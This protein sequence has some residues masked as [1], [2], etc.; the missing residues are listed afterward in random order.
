V[1]TLSHAA[2]RRS[3]EGEN[4]APRSGY[5]RTRSAARST[6]LNPANVPLCI[7]QDAGSHLIRLN[8]AGFRFQF[9]SAAIAP[10]GSGN[11]RASSAS[12]PLRAFYSVWPL[13]A[14]RRLFHSLT[15]SIP[16]QAGKQSTGRCSKALHFK[17]FRRLAG[18]V[19][20]CDGHTVVRKERACP[21]RDGSNMTRNR[22]NP[23]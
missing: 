2:D 10:P 14:A 11:S 8:S 15:S 22:A 18:L 7:R 13:K 19:A 23:T 1:V 9:R 4:T 5:G 6:K 21:T 20:L 3:G 17:P 16:F 12:A